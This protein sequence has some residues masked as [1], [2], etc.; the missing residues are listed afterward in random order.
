MLSEKNI[1]IPMNENDFFVIK[2]SE[3]SNSIDIIINSGLNFYVLNLFYVFLSYLGN[4]KCF[5]L[6]IYLCVNSKDFSN[7]RIYVYK[8]VDMYYNKNF[9]FDFFIKWL[10]GVL[11]NDLEYILDSHFYGFRISFQEFSPFW[12]ENKIYPKYPWEGE[13]YNKIKHMDKIKYYEYI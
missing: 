1:L 9:K 5:V 7:E 11:D 2:K 3:W 4:D 6:N 10:G 13:Y 8:R 12:E